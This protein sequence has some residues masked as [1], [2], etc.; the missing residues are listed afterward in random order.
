MDMQGA[1]RRE[2]E[3]LSPDVRRD[4]DAVERLL[5]P[6]F[7]EVGASGRLW[8]RADIVNL[9]SRDAETAPVTMTELR[10]L[11]LAEDLVL[12]TYVSERAGQRA[13]RCTV[14]R[15]DSDGWRALYHQGTPL[16][17]AGAP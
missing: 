13:R 4:S 16:S 3:L 5:D 12:I 1:V 10:C 9:L 14:W 2:L 15:R 11:G 17:W 8:E 7:R 6:H